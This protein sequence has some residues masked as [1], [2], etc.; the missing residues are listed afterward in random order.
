[1]LGHDIVGYCWMANL[2]GKEDVIED[3]RLLGKGIEYEHGKQ[4]VEEAM[5]IAGR[6][7]LVALK[8]ISGDET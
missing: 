6:Q 1:M 5:R 2:G 3:G 8:E 4:E 7:E